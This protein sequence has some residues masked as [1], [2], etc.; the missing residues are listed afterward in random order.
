MSRGWRYNICATF[1][2]TL[3][4]VLFLATA[5]LSNLLAFLGSITYY[6]PSVRYL[7]GAEELFDG[8]GPAFALTSLQN[9]PNRPNLPY[10]DRM[11]KGYNAVQVRAIGD[12]VRRTR[13][14]ID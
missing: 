14:R 10:H 11:E 8:A 9:D 1:Y 4:D 13:G 7:S 5:S 3:R 6:L 2:R 12:R